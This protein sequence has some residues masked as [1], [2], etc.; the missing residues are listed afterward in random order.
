MNK[1]VPYIQSCEIVTRKNFVENVRK[2]I[3]SFDMCIRKILLQEIDMQNHSVEMDSQQ[4]DIQL[5]SS[6]PVAVYEGA[7]FILLCNDKYARIWTGEPEFEDRFKKDTFFSEIKNSLL[8]SF[9]ENKIDQFIL[10]FRNY[11]FSFWNLFPVIWEWLL[12]P[13]NKTTLEQ[14]KDSLF[15]QLIFLI[16]FGVSHRVRAAPRPHA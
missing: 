7:S 15:N 2:Y 14:D 16:D 13:E 9:P 12:L 10:F 5:I 6:I 1:L 3:Q 4:Q 11:C 8:F